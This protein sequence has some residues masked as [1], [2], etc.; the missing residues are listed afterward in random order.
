MTARDDL[1]AWLEETTW[2]ENDV[3]ERLTPDLSGCHTEPEPD[4]YWDAVRWYPPGDDGVI[5]V[6]VPTP[7]EVQALISEGL[8]EMETLLTAFQAVGEVLARV[9]TDMADSLGAA[10]RLIG[11]ADL[12]PPRPKQA[13]LPAR[14]PGPRHGSAETCPRHGPTRGGTCWRCRR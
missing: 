14:R 1:A 13:A 2:A 3:P 4:G 6:E 8:A 7:A 5:Q 9:F 11:F 10:L 12:T